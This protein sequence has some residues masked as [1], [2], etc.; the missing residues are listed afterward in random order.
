MKFKWESDEDGQDLTCKFYDYTLRVEQMDKK[1]WWWRV[2]YKNKTIETPLNEYAARKW[3]AIGFTEGICLMH[4]KFHC[5]E[6]WIK[7]I[8]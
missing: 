8:D 1:Y 5:P 4:V 2:Y 3:Q 6:L 7:I